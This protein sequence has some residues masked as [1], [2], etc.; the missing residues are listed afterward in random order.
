MRCV[1]VD[2]HA[3]QPRCNACNDTCIAVVPVD[4]VKV[5]CA[6]QPAHLRDGLHEPPRRVGP[7]EGERVHPYIWTKYSRVDS[8]AALAH[9]L[10]R[11]ALCDQGPHQRCEELG[12]VEIRIT[13]LENPGHEVGA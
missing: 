9:A 10:D 1:E 12:E 7:R 6:H 11:V 13:D 4:A 3:L 8:V 2:R 5:S